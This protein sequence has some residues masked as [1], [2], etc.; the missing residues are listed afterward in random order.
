MHAPEP[1][2]TLGHELKLERV[3]GHLMQN[4]ID[5]TQERGDVR[6]RVFADGQLAILEV[7]TRAAA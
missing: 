5:A 2:I 7:K 4:A 6:I 1:V 3:I